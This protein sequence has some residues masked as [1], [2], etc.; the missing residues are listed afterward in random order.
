MKLKITKK[1]EPE[2]DEDEGSIEAERVEE[3]EDI[4]SRE[5]ATVSICGDSKIMEK[6]IVDL[7]GRPEPEDEKEWIFCD[8]CK[9]R[10]WIEQCGL[11][12]DNWEDFY[13]C[14]WCKLDGRTQRYEYEES[15][16]NDGRSV[17][18]RSRNRVRFRE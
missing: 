17:R 18:M 15:V 3:M 8:G 1:R 4:D 2:G 6:R 7:E 13:L 11:V 12:E 9:R 10:Y 5:V 14:P 16:W